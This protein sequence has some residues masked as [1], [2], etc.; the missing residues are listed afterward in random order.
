MTRK[1]LPDRRSA[2]T[3]SFELM[4]PGGALERYYATV[5]YYS[6]N[7]H[8]PFDPDLEAPGEIFINSSQKSGSQADINASD[9]AVAA[10]IAFQHGASLEELR[11]AMRRYEDGRPQSPLGAALDKIHEIAEEDKKKR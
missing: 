9:A 4:L 10:S 1:Y 3:F 2:E 11:H 5:G 8:H 7:P 6:R